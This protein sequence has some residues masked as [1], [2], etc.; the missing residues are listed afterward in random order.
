MRHLWIL[1]AGCL[2]LSTA[3]AAV[4]RYT[5]AN[6]RV[7]FTDQPPL[8]VDASELELPEPNSTLMPTPHQPAATPD[9]R[10]GLTRPPYSTLALEGIPDAEAIRANNGSFSLEVVIDPPLRRGHQLQLLVDGEPHGQP[11]QG[12]QLQANNLDRGEHQLAV[13]VQAGPKVLQSSA[14][15]PVSVQRTHVNSP[16]RRAP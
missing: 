1:L 5:D 16:A 11:V 14:R 10:P 9:A 2:A 8:G 15:Y 3:Q 12:T 4:Y 13:Q 7:V 6:G